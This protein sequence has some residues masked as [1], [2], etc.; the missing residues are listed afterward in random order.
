MHRLRQALLGCAL[1]ACSASAALP[2]GPTGLTCTARSGAILRLN[3]D[4]AG[5]QFQKEGFPILPMEKFTDQ[6]IVLMRNAAGSLSLE[7]SIDRR[8]LV[9]T[10]R[11][12]DRATRNTTRTDYQCVAGPP[13]SASDER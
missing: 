10:A 6:V 5:R 12:E 7:A 13:F 8:I 3:I 2:D 1:F 9:Y 11:S 4:P